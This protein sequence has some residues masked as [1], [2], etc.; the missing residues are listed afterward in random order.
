MF[1]LILESF[2]WQVLSRAWVCAGE[3]EWPFLASGGFVPTIVGAVM[4][5]A[6]G[7]TSCLP[8]FVPL[9]SLA[10]FS[11]EKISPFTL[12]L[13]KAGQSVIAA[14]QPVAPLVSQHL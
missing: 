10:G 12:G 7:G 4:S 8:P 6:A 11:G 9:S 5:L 2:S 3:Q 14:S 1:P 13:P